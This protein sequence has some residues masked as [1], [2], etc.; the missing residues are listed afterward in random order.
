L[1]IYWANSL[2]NEADRRF[3]EYCAAKL[4]HAGY[5]VFLPQEADENRGVS[6][7]AQDIFR[8][9]TVRVMDSDLMVA[10]LDQETIDCGVAC[11]I[12]LA[13]SYNVPIV[14]LYTDIR[15]QRQGIG[16]MYKNLYVVG[17]IEEVGEIV[18]SVDELLRILP[19]YLS[20]E[21]MEAPCKV[22]SETVEDHFS[23]VA[24]TYPDFV[25][26][27]ESWY[28]PSW[29]VN[30][31]IDTVLRSEKPQRILEI[32]CGSGQTGRYITSQY[33][34]ASY[35]GYDPSRRMISIAE[36]SARN[37]RY[38]SSIREVESLARRTPFDLTMAFF[39]LHDHQDKEASLA[40]MQRLTGPRGLI[41]LVDLSTQDLPKLIRA[42]RYG[43]GRPAMCPD[44][45]IET[46]WLAMTARKLGLDIET[47]ELATPTV[48]FPCVNDILAYASTFGIHLG[49]DFPLALDPQDS[50]RN[51]LL[52]RGALSLLAF[53]FTDQRVFV[54]C[55]LRNQ[56]NVAS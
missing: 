15:Q 53:P 16:R 2:F 25:Q 47:L 39:T 13:Y 48:S 35:V 56:G 22:H 29:S 55:K 46:C 12:G 40:L 41:H 20:P 3:N 5:E 9:D 44:P 49:M 36:K 37:D 24:P 6:P 4:R 1:K 30:I 26:Q 8:V 19:R 54:A 33:P 31:L 28:L 43:L 7:T 50:S 38:T 32:G 51:I 10:C 52:I 45:R 23:E 21:A 34:D 14:G 17:A 42:L 11:E 27:L 18:T